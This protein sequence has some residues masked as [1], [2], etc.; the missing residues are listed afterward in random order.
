MALQEYLASYAVKVD[1]DGA[2]RLQ[3]I[4]DQ[5]RESAAELT[6]AFSSARSALAGLK[7]ELSDTVGLKNVLSSLTGGLSSS[8]SNAAL[9]SGSG[10]GLSS[11][12]AG[13]LSKSSASVAV[14]ADMSA[15]NEALDSYKAKAETLRPK[16]SVNATGITSAVSS[17]IAS[18]RSM[19][20]SVSVSIPVKAVASLDTSSLKKQASGVTLTG[21]TA[22]TYG[23]GGRVSSPTLAMIAEEG[24]PEYVIPVKNEE[25]ALPLI[26]QMMGELSDAAKQQLTGGLTDAGDLRSSLSRLTDAAGNQFALG[27]SGSMAAVHSVEAPVTINV[28]STAAP[29]EAVGQ[30]IYDTA[31]RSLLKTL[32]GVFA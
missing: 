15:A 31:R 18:V 5:N 14:S 4:L 20:S 11:V 3:R 2:R 21:V 26:R 7:A 6:E 24:E 28:T 29:A 25:R 12:S 10:E 27:S 22:S 19:L 13:S 1:E 8:F 17:A 16:L 30:F 23:I 32:E 9:S